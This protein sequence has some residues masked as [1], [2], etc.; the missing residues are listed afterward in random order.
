MPLL[1]L[2]L[3]VDGEALAKGEG[4][5][6]TTQIIKRAFLPFLPTSLDTRSY[7]AVWDKGQGRLSAVKEFYSN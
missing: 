7:Q 6:S 1:V 4:L 5:F 3:V 2:A